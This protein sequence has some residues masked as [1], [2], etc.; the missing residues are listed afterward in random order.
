MKLKTL[1]TLFFLT[2]LKGCSSEKCTCPLDNE[3]LRENIESFKEIEKSDS[4][5]ELGLENYRTF[6][7]DTYRLTIYPSWKD[8]KISEYKLENGWG[9][10][11]ISI[12]HYERMDYKEKNQ[13]KKIGKTEKISLSENEWNQFDKLMREQCFWTMP[14]RSKSMYLD[15]TG[16]ILE[17][18]K[19]RKNRCTNQNYHIVSR[20]ADSPEY[21]DLCDK[22]LKLANSSKREQDSLLYDSWTSD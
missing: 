12:N 7:N 6:K 1:F 11:K 21:F 19:G 22:L 13:L 20:V 17:V 4:W 5:T 2:L 15:G 9:S 8:S 14:V 3:T 18:K 10:P 16:W